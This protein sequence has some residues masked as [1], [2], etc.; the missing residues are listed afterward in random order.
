MCTHSE[1]L[2][3]YHCL[4]NTV[5]FIF[6]DSGKAN[7]LWKFS[8][9]QPKSC[10]V[11]QFSYG[12]PEHHPPVIIIL[13]FFHILLFSYMLASSTKLS[14]PLSQEL[15]HVSRPPVLSVFWICCCLPLNELHLGLKRSAYSL[16][17]EMF[18]ELMGEQKQAGKYLRT[19]NGATGTT[20][21]VR[22]EDSQLRIGK[23]GGFTFFLLFLLAAWDHKINLVHSLK[24]ENQKDKVNGGKNGGLVEEGR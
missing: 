24:T 4:P 3:A 12:I 2:F 17:G 14:D 5:L 6:H 16:S 15:F 1:F 19:A 22:E 11:S 7:F 21:Q 18:L 20:T 8:W 13:L 9:R 10:R 23:A